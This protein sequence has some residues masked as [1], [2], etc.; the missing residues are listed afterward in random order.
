MRPLPFKT[1]LRHQLIPCAMKRARPSWTTRSHSSTATHSTFDYII[2]GAGSA[3]CVLANRLTEDPTKSVLLVEAGQS[4]RNHLD[5]WTIQMPSA[6]TYNLQELNS[7]DRLWRNVDKKDSFG[8]NWGFQTT[9]QKNVNNRVIEQPRG[10]VLGGSSSINAM[11]YVRGHAFDY[12]R[13]H[14]EIQAGRPLPEFDDASHEGEEA[15]K[16]KTAGGT[17]TTPRWDYAA[18]LP[19]FRKAECYNEGLLEL[20]MD[21]RYVGLEGPLQVRHGKTKVTAPLNEVLIQAGKQAGYPETHDPNGYMQEGF[22]PMHMTVASNGTRSSTA[23]AYLRP[24]LEQRPNLTVRTEARVD[25]ILFDTDLEKAWSP[26]MAEEAEKTENAGKAEEAATTTT[27]RAVGIRCMDGTEL[28]LTTCHDSEII[29]SLGAIGSPHLL[30]LSGIGPRAHLEKVGIETLVNIDDVGANLQDHLDT[31]IQYECK[32]P[33]TLYPDATFPHRMIKSG[34]EWFGL[35]TGICASNHFE[36]GGF[37]RT[38]PGKR[39]PDLQ[40]HFIAACVVGQA[41]FLKRHGFQLHCSTMRASSVGT[42]QLQSNKASDP[43][44]IDPNYLDTEED[45]V[46]YRNAVRLAIEI[47]EQPA[48]DQYRGMRLSPDPTQY[49]LNN[50][51]DVDRWIRETTHSAYHPCGTCA[52]GRVVDGEGRVMGIESLRVVDSS[53]MPSV[54]SGNLNAPTIMLAEKMSD[55][56][57]GREQIVPDDGVPVYLAEEWETKQR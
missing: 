29:L 31:Y 32:Q 36:T 55:F 11:A 4:D 33:T 13:W 57:R 34:I 28:F 51:D 17:T 40:F 53:I 25:R 46:D 54:P 47:L 12:D 43:P 5:S 2:V 20:G 30:M 7:L 56:I 35:G 18:C 41:T 21:E 26:T 44:I 52:M 8:Y 3:G 49:D 37:I 24:I 23:N 42:L 19:Y 48:M 10:K 27:P 50:D 45:V 6:L 22:G 16:L 9:P 15:R 14:A 1:A 38:A 39:H